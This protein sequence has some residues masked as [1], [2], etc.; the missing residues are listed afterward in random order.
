MALLEQGRLDQAEP[1]FR[2]ALRI[3]PA[4]ALAW[5]GLARLQAEQGDFELSSQSARAA[6]ALRPTLA[7][8]HWRL[9]INL[10][11][12]L[13]D[14]E[15]QAIERLLDQKY[16]PVST[17]SMLH[18]C[19]AAVFDARG[20]YVR[21]AAL[22]EAAHALQSSAR[23]ARGQVHDPG[24]HSRF[25]DRLIE[26]F[27]PD[28]IDRARGWGDPD[29]R[30]V[31]VVG[32]PRSGTTLVEQILAAHP[33]VHG[34][35]ELPDL[36]RVFNSL[37][38]RTGQPPVSPSEALHN[39]SP[40]SARKAARLYLDRL[41]AL[42]PRAATRVVD[43]M[44]DN[45]RLLG[46]IAILWPS[47]RV[48]VC[49]RDLRDVALSCWQTGFTQNP[50]NNDWDHLA[51][52]FADHQRILNHWRRTRPLEWLDVSYEELVHD[53]EANARRMV[54]FVGLPWDPACLE[55]HSMRRVV[56]TASLVQVR[57]PIHSN[58]V[59]RWRRYEP[60]LQPLFQA[61]QSHGVELDDDHQKSGRS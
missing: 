12:R 26:A 2:E 37:L 47:A 32:L 39:L 50:W 40:Q 7:E 36:H 15:V 14:A 58:S 60:S 5:T 28:D 31:L 34:A 4:L 43:K 53:P 38:E 1:C 41:D 61:F 11:G 42:A 44:P 33:Q 51:Q 27:T 9:A 3:D 54:E 29:P 56:R 22:Y 57:Q 16:L 49:C 24:R 21:A 45:L 23:A 59:G 52:R 17:R 10:K 8:A 18:F 48:I 30:P 20:L 19:L 35:G 6:L 25:I 13:T 55:F 46:L